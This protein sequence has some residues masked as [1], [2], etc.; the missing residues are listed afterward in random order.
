MNIYKSDFVE[1][2][3]ARNE[4]NEISNIHMNIID[5]KL[6]TEGIQNKQALDVLRMCLTMCK[7]ER[8]DGTVFVPGLMSKIISEIEGLV[9]TPYQQGLVEALRTGKN[10]PHALIMI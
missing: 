8:I 10:N 5:G 1:I 9:L 3:V 4:F 2:G 7:H 6:P